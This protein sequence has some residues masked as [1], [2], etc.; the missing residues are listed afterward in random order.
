MRELTRLAAVALWTVL[1][2]RAGV[3]QPVPAL[4]RGVPQLNVRTGPGTEHPPVATVREGEEVIVQKVSRSWAFIRTQR[5]ET[6]YVHVNYLNSLG[7]PMPREETPPS[8]TAPAVAVQSSPTPDALRERAAALEAEVASLRAQL[9]ALQGEAAAGTRTEALHGDI[10]HVLRLTEEM[11]AKLTTLA[12]DGDRARSD[13]FTSAQRIWVSL[14]AGL[15]IGVLLGSAY[16]RRQER[17]RRTR[18]RF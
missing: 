6:G 16:G 17:S 10:R 14:G 4:V 13:A 15:I 18:I 3:A 11:H 2:A 12:L 1:A 8:P 7:V 5:G 9:V